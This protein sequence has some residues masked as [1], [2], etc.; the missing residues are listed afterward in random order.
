[1]KK[2]STCFTVNFQDG[3]NTDQESMQKAFEKFKQM[4]QKNLKKLKQMKVKVQQ[5]LQDPDQRWELRMKFLQ[6][7]K[8]YI[9]M[10][11]HK[12]YHP[13]GS[14]EYESPLFLDCCGLIRK[15][16]LDL[17]EDFG[18]VIGPGNQAYQ[19]DTLPFTLA[20]EAD[21]KPGDLVFISG[22]YFN[23]QTIFLQNFP[24]PLEEK[25]P[26][27]RILP[28]PCLTVVKRQI[29]DMVHVEIWLGEGERTL[30]ARWHRGKV[31][32][33]DSYNHCSQHKWGFPKQLPSP[34]SIFYEEDVQEEIE[35]EESNSEPGIMQLKHGDQTEP[36]EAKPENSKDLQ[37][38]P[39]TGSKV[40]SEGEIDIDSPSTESAG[41]C[42]SPNER[43]VSALDNQAQETGQPDAK[44]ET[45]SKNI[46]NPRKTETKTDTSANPKTA[47]ATVR[48]MKK[49]KK[50]ECR[51]QGEEQEQQCASGPAAE[52][53]PDGLVIES[54]DCGKAEGLSKLSFKRSSESD[55]KQDPK[56]PGPFFYIGG[57][58]GGALVGAYCLSKGW[59]RINNKNREDYKLKWCE[60][61]SYATY[62]NFH[63]GEQLV[64]QIPN[65][66]VLTTKIGL[67]SSLRE[68]ERVVTKVQ[69][70]RASKLLKLEDFFPDTFRMDVKEEREAFFALYEERQVWICKPT[71]LNQGRGIFLLKTAEDMED[72]RSRLQ[73]IEE[74]P[75]YKK[76]PFKSPQARIVQRYVQNP[77]LLEGK[78]FDVRSYF[79]IASTVPYMVFFRHGYVRLTCESY[80][81]N[82]NDLTAHL[83]NQYMQKKNPLYNDL[84][85]ETVWSME[86][87]NDYVNEKS[88]A[89]KGLPE[90]WV[91]TVFATRMQQIMMQC[92]LAVKSKLECKLGY[93]D[94]IG[95]DFL[96]DEDFKVWLL[97]MNCNPALHTNCEVLKE[98]IPGVVNET[99]DLAF[100]IFNKYRKGRS[101]MPLDAQKDFTLLYNGE[102]ND[103]LVKPMRSRAAGA[104]FQTATRPKSA[105]QTSPS[106]P[107][108]SE[109]KQR[110]AGPFTAKVSISAASQPLQR[111]AQ[112]EGTETPNNPS[113]SSVKPKN[114]AELKPSKSTLSRRNDPNS[115]DLGNLTSPILGKE[116]AKVATVSMPVLSE[117]SFTSSHPGSFSTEKSPASTSRSYSYFCLGSAQVTAVKLQPRVPAAKFLNKEEI[118]AAD[119]AEDHQRA[120]E[121]DPKPGKEVPN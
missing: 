113:P 14:P 105:T 80:D 21:M 100:E 63:Q 41:V 51:G 74:N 38:V 96:I 92:F 84:K 49:K 10:P 7:A 107:K 86:R 97:E 110:Q 76:I 118:M 68:Y 62:I 82:S 13:P 111:P 89:A 81:P 56:G 83:T 30:G 42:T 77:L 64:Y 114:K 59:Q 117:R 88:R 91:C 11:Y 78:K 27:R 17:K 24:V 53:A 104:N 4:H 50:V 120:S 58:N 72:F 103:L 112:E 94:L 71:G 25:Q 115:S 95:C 69:L 79:L 108:P 65:N 61:K 43:E 46:L 39:R 26:H 102:L 36:S 5:R 121:E 75:L 47:G 33:F 29:H 18:F 44:P 8:S 16:L 119:P 99:L 60:T 116:E 40:H 106:P 73:N 32:I 35:L 52:E 90:D 98:V 67:L 2:A 48:K 1:M 22:S 15:V 109:K 20:T 93:F 57:G 6:Q 87:F 45:K 101:I 34:K 55:K 12:R 23:T 66:K 3:Q 70:G 19:Y 9:G 28:S 31:Q 37:D 54:P 85:E